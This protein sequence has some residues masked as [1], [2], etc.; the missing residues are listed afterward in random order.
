MNM[1]KF[2]VSVAAAVFALGIFALAVLDGAPAAQAASLAGEKEAGAGYK[3]PQRAEKVRSRRGREKVREQ[4]PACPLRCDD[5]TYRGYRRHQESVFSWFPPASVVAAPFVGAKCSTA[6]RC[7]L[8]NPESEGA[9][10]CNQDGCCQY[11]ST[12]YGRCNP[13]E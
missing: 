1:L 13:C 8:R 7:Y 11:H 2:V 3:P 10:M 9:C 5:V 4:R 6:D 12:Y